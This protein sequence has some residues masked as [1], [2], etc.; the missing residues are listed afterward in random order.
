MDDFDIV[1]TVRALRCEADELPAKIEAARCAINA[2]A[3]TRPT[4]DVWQDMCE[5]E[6][7]LRVFF[8]MLEGRA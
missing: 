3:P 1:M 2:K 7:K 4:I 5:R 8:A 6:H